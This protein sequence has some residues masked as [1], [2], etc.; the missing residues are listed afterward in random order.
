MCGFLMVEDS[1]GLASGVS[2]L[3]NSDSRLGR[4]VLEPSLGFLM[5]A[6]L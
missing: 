6:P 5:Y 3:G 4:K 2:V 1:S